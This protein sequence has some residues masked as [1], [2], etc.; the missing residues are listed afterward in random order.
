MTQN[1]IKIIKSLKET[2]FYQNV[3]LHIHTDCS[4]GKLSPDKVIEAA[5]SQNIK[6]I[7]ITD[8]NSVEAYSKIKDFN[9]Q[10]QLLTGVEFDCWE[11]TDFLHILGYGF[12]LANDKIKKLCANDLA[13]CRYDILRFFT[14]RKAKDAITAIK[15]AGG[16]AVLAHPACCWSINIRKMIKK[17][18]CCGL[19]GLEVYYPYTGHR[20]LVKFYSVEYIKS[21]AEE[22]DLLITGGADSHGD[23]LRER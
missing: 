14:G 5:I 11:G 17:L 13:H 2:D 15:E 21:L 19:D 4:D 1:L 9:N 10:I 23:E 3:N 20:K 22:L 6:I 12:D 18:V 7:S 8:H 16:I